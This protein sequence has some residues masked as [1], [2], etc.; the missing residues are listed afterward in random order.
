MALGTAAVLLL[1]SAYSYA[2][3]H[4]R[5]NTNTSESDIIEA[6]MGKGMSWIGTGAILV[7]NIVSIVVI[8][9]V[10]TRLLAPSG[11]WFLQVA[12]AVFL[13]SC[14][15]GLAL[16]GIELNKSVTNATTYALI[17]VL[18]IAAFMGFGGAFMEGGHAV[19]GDFMNSVWMFLYVLVGFDAIMKFTEESVVD[20]DV[21][22]AFFLS[23]GISIV[24]TLGV[25]AAIASWLPPLTKDSESNALGLLFAK[26]FGKGVLGSFRWL[27][28]VFLLLT[29]FVVFLATSR[30]LYGLG[31]KM[32]F[33]SPLTAVNEAQAPWVSIMT[34]FGVGA[35]LSMINHVD[36]LVIITDVGFAVIATLV[37]GSVA[38]ADWHDGFLT[39]AA[40][41]GA[42]ASGFLGLITTAFLYR[43]KG[44]E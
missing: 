43:I 13:L 25:A 19:P 3:A 34:V 20:S 42:T 39:S 2:G 6:E 27:M 5:F 37:A 30:Y 7:Y 18:V 36:T 17:G 22:T 16:T 4:S 38:I 41:N 10:C 31:E 15:T 23:N 12:T 33:L 44:R 11:T 21:Q 29:V 1:G 35:V 9:V 26:F 24:L 32:E 8:L 28:I 40:I 14:M